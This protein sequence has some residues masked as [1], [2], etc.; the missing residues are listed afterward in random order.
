MTSTYDA[1]ASAAVD[2]C[3]D[4][5]HEEPGGHQTCVTLQ[6]LCNA[7]STDWAHPV[8]ATHPVVK[9]GDESL[10]DVVDRILVDM[11]IATVSVGGPFPS[12]CRVPATLFPCQLRGA[13][14]AD[15]ARE[16]CTRGFDARVYAGTVRVQLSLAM[17]SAV[18]H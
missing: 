7:I 9:V 5:T 11:C 13:D 12:V 10:A 4:L 16:L 17:W 8:V 18:N 2:A 6:A 15:V 14:A 3:R 1:E